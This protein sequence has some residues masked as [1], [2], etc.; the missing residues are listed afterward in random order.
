MGFSSASTILGI[1]GI[2]EGVEVV[3]VSPRYTSQT[4]HQCLHTHPVKGKFYCQ[5]TTFNCGYSRGKGDGDLN[6]AMQDRDVGAVRK[7]AC[8]AQ[9]SILFSTR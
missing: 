5:A 6:G 8:N 7:P 1:Q 4:C 3:T 2:I 9:S